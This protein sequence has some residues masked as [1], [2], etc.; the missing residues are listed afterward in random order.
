MS[1]TQIAV[2]L[3]CY[4]EALTIASV[5][6]AFRES[7]PEAQIYVFDNNSNDGSAALAAAAG[8]VVVPVPLQG[9]G[10]VVRRMFAEVDADIYLM[11]DA[12]GTY[13][14]ARARSLIEPIQSGH[15][16]TVVATRMGGEGAFPP[17]HRFGNALFNLIVRRIFGR[18][19]SD[20][21]SGYRSFSRRFVK[22]F[23][24]HSERFD[25]ETELSIFMLEQRIPLLEIPLQ[26]GVRPEGSASKLNTYRTATNNDH[27]LWLLL[28]HHRFSVAHYFFTILL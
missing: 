1:H 20:I 7:L 26:Y 27:A 28:H 18:G 14:A 12:D 6:H 23:P 10:N 9:K 21:F 11:A 19:L 2:L 22:S 13:D 25:I 24:A 4:N 15:Y 17:G 5:I 16:D 3:P 8:A